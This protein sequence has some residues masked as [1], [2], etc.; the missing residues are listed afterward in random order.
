M[1]LSRLKIVSESTE[2]RFRTGVEISCEKCFNITPNQSLFNLQYM[3]DDFSRNHLIF[4][5]YWMR[6]SKIL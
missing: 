6:F 5:N 3:T 2:K 4:N 1:T